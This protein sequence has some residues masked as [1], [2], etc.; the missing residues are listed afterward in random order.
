M[1]LRLKKRWR[2]WARRLTGLLVTVSLCASLFPLLIGTH[3][4]AAKDQSQPFPCQSRPCGCRS[5]EQCWKSCCCFSN[6]E[7]LVWAEAHDV[8]APAFVAE[9]AARESAVACH[10]GDGDGGSAHAES[11]S[12]T[13]PS[14]DFHAAACCD[15]ADSPAPQQHPAAPDRVQPEAVC[16]IGILMQQCQGQGAFWNA[17]PWAVLPRDA[18]IERQVDPIAWVRP[19]STGIAAA[20]GEP[21]RRPPRG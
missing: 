10:A 12:S 18:T 11:H 7:K 15:V 1:S 20:A 8:P 17:L 19:E 6:I 13:G 16:V 3:S 2:G 14:A 5:A 21:P 9:A 4:S